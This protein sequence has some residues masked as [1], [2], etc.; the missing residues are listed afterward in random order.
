LSERGERDRE[1]MFRAVLFV[2]RYAAFGK[3]EC[4][5]VAVLHH[6]HI[7]LVP[8]PRGKNVVGVHYRREPF[9]LPQRGHRFV[10][11]SA[12]SE[13][14]AGQGM[15]QGQ[16][17]AIPRR[18]QRGRGLHDVLADD[19]HV[20]DLPITLSQLVVGETDRARVV[21]GGCLLQRAAVER[22]GARLIAA[23]RGQ[24]AVE[25]PERREAAC[26]LSVAKSV[27][28]PAKRGRG[29]I[30]IVLQQSVFGEYR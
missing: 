18:V 2:K 17:T 26:R 30:E 1:T 29:L 16:V 28:G 20:A 8:A 23:R 25:P 11:A 6:H 13:G 12:L 9:G 4:L 14:D 24:T 3:R 27:L 21:S 19:G 22:D 7:R 15:N 10:V 5:L